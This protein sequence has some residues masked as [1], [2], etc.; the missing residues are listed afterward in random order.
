MLSDRQELEIFSAARGLGT[1]A[2][3]AGWNLEQ[4][5]PDDVRLVFFHGGGGR[6][7]GSGSGNCHGTRVRVSSPRRDKQMDVIAHQAAEN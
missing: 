2:R 1:T 7:S 3:A 5:P 6:A 4:R